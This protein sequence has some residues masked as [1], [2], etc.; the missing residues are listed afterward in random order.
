MSERDELIDCLR[1]R[2]VATTAAQ[3]RE[4]ADLLERDGVEI[5]RLRAYIQEMVEKAAAKSLDG[6][7]ELGARAAAAEN[8]LDAA[9][10]AL[11]QWQDASQ[12]GHPDPCSLGPLCPYCEIGRLRAALADEQ[13]HTAFLSDALNRHARATDEHC[14]DCCCARSWAALG[15]TGYTGKSIPEHIEALRAA[16]AEAQKA[17]DNTAAA[18]L[19]IGSELAADPKISPEDKGDPRWTPALQEAAELRAALAHAQEELRVCQ[20]DAIRLQS[21]LTEREAV[22]RARPRRT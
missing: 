3:M 7:R 12:C 19:M 9:R 22:R 4:A 11:A 13:S 20:Q 10:A 21:A 1:Y 5:A 16:L 6:Y 18:I 14:K 2:P 8:E 17:R 15:I